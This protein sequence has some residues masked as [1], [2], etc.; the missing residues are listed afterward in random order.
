MS[1]VLPRQ[2]FG[3]DVREAFKTD[4]FRVPYKSPSPSEFGYEFHGNGHNLR[5]LPEEVEEYLDEKGLEAYFVSPDGNCLFRALTYGPEWSKHDLARLAAAAYI[6]GLKQ[7]RNDLSQVFDDEQA[8]MIRI[9][10]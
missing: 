6:F 4:T 1:P 5:L 2:T 10:I 3:S 9:G 8:E 7:E